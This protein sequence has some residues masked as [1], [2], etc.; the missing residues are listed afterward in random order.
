MCQIISLNLLLECRRFEY[1]LNIHIEHGE[2]GLEL[3]RAL[4]NLNAFLF[5][6]FI[7]E[8]D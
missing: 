4:L 1:I 6:Q 2:V 8:E 7:C 5:V 3:L